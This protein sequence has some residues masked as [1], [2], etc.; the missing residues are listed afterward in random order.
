MMRMAKKKRRTGGQHVT[1]RGT[2]QIPTEWLKII[3]RL[4]SIKKQPQMWVVV[5]L[6]EA[7]AKRLGIP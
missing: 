1:G 5:D 3:K 4:A 7:E 2:M 6:V